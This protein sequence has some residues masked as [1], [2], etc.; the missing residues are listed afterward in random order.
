MISI[1]LRATNYIRIYDLGKLLYLENIL[2]KL[3]LRNDKFRWTRTF[4]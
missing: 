1:E 3:S 4:C 2:N